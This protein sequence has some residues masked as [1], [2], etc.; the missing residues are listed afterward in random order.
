MVTSIKQSQWSF[1]WVPVAYL[2]LIATP[3]FYHII[4]KAGLQCCVGKG[5]TMKVRVIFMTL[6]TVWWINI[7]VSCCLKYVSKKIVSTCLVLT[8]KKIC[9]HNE[10]S[11]L[12]MLKHGNWW[13]QIFWCLRRKIQCG[14]LHDSMAGNHLQRF[15]QC[16]KTEY[17][18][19]LRE[20][21]ICMFS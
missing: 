7:A 8:L 13:P 4:L 18:L 15:M 6:E 20:E 1:D 17:F 16:L 19:N 2:Y 14:I 10:C 9:T 3:F 12:A 11:K 21:V 5:Y